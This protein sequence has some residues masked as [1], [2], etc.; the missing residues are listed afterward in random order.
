MARDAWCLLVPDLMLSGP[1]PLDIPCGKPCRG[2]KADAAELDR[3]FLFRSADRH[4][5]G[6]RLLGSPSSGPTAS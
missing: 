6:R 4:A 3:A 1:Y 2:L 5:R